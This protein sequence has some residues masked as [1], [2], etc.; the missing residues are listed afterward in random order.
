[1]K[2]IIVSL[3][4]SNRSMFYKRKKNELTVEFGDLNEVGLDSR[5]SI[6]PF[7]SIKD[8]IINKRSVRSMSTLRRPVNDHF[9]VAKGTKSQLGE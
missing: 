8:S 1:M 3:V 7:S 2:S 6:R 4:K 5:R 9:M